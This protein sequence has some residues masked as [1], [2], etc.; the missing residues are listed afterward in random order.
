M[1]EAVICFD[2]DDV[3]IRLSIYEAHA[4]RAGRRATE[5]A[6]LPAIEALLNTDEKIPE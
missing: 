5:R 1:P 3:P 4:A 2:W 6:R